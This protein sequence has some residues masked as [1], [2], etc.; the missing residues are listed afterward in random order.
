MGPDHPDALAWLWAQWGTTAALRHVAVAPAPALR[1]PV[2][3]GIATLR[4]TFWSAAWT[5]WR[6]LAAVAARWP[7]V[8]FELRPS[9]DVP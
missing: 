2:P 6:A 4:F 5:P 9:Y 7:A 3:A 1:T 8:R